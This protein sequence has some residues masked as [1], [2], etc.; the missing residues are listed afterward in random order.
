MES[1][2]S[3]SQLKQHLPISFINNKADYFELKKKKNSLILDAILVG[4]SLPDQ[5]VWP[6]RWF[7]STPEQPPPAIGSSMKARERGIFF[8]MVRFAQKMQG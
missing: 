7:A 1:K 8:E 2:P 5:R 4:T 3:W 6:K